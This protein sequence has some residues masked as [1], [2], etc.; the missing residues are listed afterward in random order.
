MAKTPPEGAVLKTFREI[1]DV[2]QE[3][4]A[5]AAGLTRDDIQNLEK[6]RSQLLMARLPFLGRLL[7]FPEAVAHGL[8]RML[9]LLSASPL[10]SSV[11]PFGLPLA[12]RRIIAGAAL[13]HAA[14]L[15]ERLAVE[16]LEEHVRADREEAQGIWKV[17]R[18]WPVAECWKFLE[19]ARQFA[20]WALVERLAEESVRAAAADIARTLEIAELACWTAGLVEGVQAWRNRVA[21]YA[22]AF[23][24][25]AQR[26]AE[27]YKAAEATLARAWALWRSGGVDSSGPLNESR[28]YDLESSLRCDLHQWEAAMEAL[29]LARCHCRSLEGESRILLKMASTL[30]HK[31]DAQEAL[32]VLRRAESLVDEEKEP[33]Q[34]FGL[35]FT[36]AVNLCHLRRFEEASAMLEDLQERAMR[37]GNELDVVRLVWMR[38][39]VVLGLGREEDAEAD[40]LQVQRDFKT[41][42]LLYDLAEVDLEI[43]RLYLRQGRLA[44]TRELA[45]AAEPVFRDL[46]VVQAAQEAMSIFW[47]V[48]RAEKATVE[49]AE[50]A[51]SVLLEFRPPLAA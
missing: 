1:E 24:A 43:A 26:V 23:V 13:T 45:T 7:R 29:E 8:R 44:E 42:G 10:E 47:E 33:R 4:L 36:R 38:S 27:D 28:L 30:Q 5:R 3:D 9:G 35:L 2:T 46:G 32:E 37:L 31:G 39:R 48:A 22:L 14:N 16:R 6:G 11:P 25:N 41:R 50:Q 40:L 17:L 51:L 15:A 18:T 49:M 12:E 21:A 20:S 19:E 34:M